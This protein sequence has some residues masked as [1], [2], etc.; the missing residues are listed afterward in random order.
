MGQVVQILE[1]LLDVNDPPIH[2]YLQALMEGEETTSFF[3]K[4]S[5]ATSLAD[6]MLVGHSLTRNRT[7]V[8]KG[9]KFELGFFTPGNSQKHYIGIWYKQVPSVQ[10]KK[11]IVWV[12]NRNKPISATDLSSSEFKL[13]ED[14]QLVL[15]FMKA[16]NNYS[17]DEV[18]IWSTNSI[19]SRTMIYSSIKVVLHDN[20]NLAVSSSSNGNI[21]IMWQSFDHP[22]NYLLPGAKFGYNNLTNTSQILTSWRNSEDPSDGF[23]SVKL[24]PG[25]TVSF[26]WNQS[27][28]FYNSGVWNGRYFGNFP[29]MRI[30]VASSYE[31]RSYANGSYFIYSVADADPPF[32]AFVDVSGQL[33]AAVWLSETQDWMEIWT[34]PMPLCQVYGTCGA[35][36][37]CS[38]NNIGPSTCQ[39]LPGF[40]KHNPKDLD[41][42]DSS[43]GCVR[44]TSLW[45][46]DKDI[47]QVMRNMDLSKIIIS[48]NVSVVGDAKKCKSSCLQNCSCNAYAYHKTGSNNNSIGCLLWY[49]SLVNVR[50]HVG[51][52]GVDLFIRLAASEDHLP[53][54]RKK[55]STVAIVGA[56]ISGLIILGGIT[57]VFLHRYSKRRSSTE[58]QKYAFLTA[59]RYKDLKIATKNFS[60]ELGSGGF[61]CVFKG[62]LPDSTAIAVKKL[63]VVTQEEKQFRRE[64]STIGLIHHVNL[65][66]LR[67]FCSEGA[68]RMLVYDFMPNGSLERHLFHQNNSKI[69]NWEQRYQIA[70]GTARGLAYLHDECRDCIIHCDIKPENILLDADFSPKIADFGLA[71]LL[72]REFSRVLTFARGTVGY[73]APEWTSGVAITSKV[74]VYSYGMMLFELISGRRNSRHANGGRVWFFPTWAA[75]KVVSEGQSVLS[76][77]DDNLAGN[78]N[79]EELD[80][81]F[82]VAYWCIQEAETQ[83]PSMARVVQILEGLLDVNYP[84]NDRHLQ[85][86]M[87]ASEE[88]SSFSFKITSKAT[89]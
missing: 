27:H 3:S 35:F 43:S 2:R 25:G 24:E 49:G 1:G 8:S 50:Q 67:G 10:K 28:E 85:A 60:D 45:C 89:T 62:K 70:L 72:G 74:D 61:G 47:F 18:P 23:Y 17:S 4:S 77:L 57:I 11:T 79:V 20:G 82:K 44:K 65:V 66:R 36:S 29:E 32:H 13:L 19:T 16:K 21:I 75:K 53:S 22:T 39:C 69:L 42:L 58:T 64:V 41:S 38:D 26:I 7:L 6:T 9:G 52:D 30:G 59:F 37:I 55:I 83:R 78:A 48:A 63:E 84:P 33:K 40:E 51:D 15:F 12:A 34:K 14:G 88:T 86:P 87:M 73:L 31:Y 81:A 56:V 54:S 46:G 71:K 5:S 80:R 76:I 68:K